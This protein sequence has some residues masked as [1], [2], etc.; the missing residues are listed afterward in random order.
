[1]KILILANLEDRHIAQIKAIAPEAELM[2]TTD[3]NKAVSL[4][5]EAEIM[6]GWNL[7]R[8]AIA[9]A[10]NLKWIHSTAA[11]VDQLLFPEILERE[12]L[13][14]TSSGIHAIPLCE[15][16]FAMMLALSRRLHYAI[17]QQIHRRWDRR[18]SVGGE[19]G[20]GTLG[21]LGLGHI[22][23]ELAKRAVAFE[24]RVIGTK[25]TPSPVPFVERVLPPEGLDEVLMESDVVVIALPLTPQTRG[26]IGERELRLMKPTAFLINVGRGP[27]VQE[28]ALIRALREGWIAGAALDVFEQE[29]LPADSPL[30][31][32]ENVILTPHV[33]G[34]SP[35]YMD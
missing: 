15:H 14:T 6:V 4:A 34:T 25:R 18:G 32:L 29:P 35:R 30:Y 21:I 13:V 5:P 7:P 11:G 12:I 26:L 22:G 10:P 1:M 3:R 33:A 20:G 17:R 8:E 28:R 23:V 27:I 16:V 31:D 19:L 9:Q 24:M 2:V